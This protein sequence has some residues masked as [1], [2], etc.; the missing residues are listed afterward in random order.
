MRDPVE[1]P[2][3]L[4]GP[5]KHREMTGSDLDGL[6]SQHGR[7]DATRPLRVEELVF[8]GENEPA[9]KVW[10]AAGLIAIRCR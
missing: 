4:G 6:G 5:F 7:R 1:E 2:R 3:E 8:G 9:W 10:M